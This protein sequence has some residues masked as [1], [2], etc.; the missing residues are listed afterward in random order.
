MFIALVSKTFRAI[1][2]LTYYL[3]TYTITLA[4]GSMLLLFLFNPGGVGGGGP[5]GGLIF[6]IYITAI[7]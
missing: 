3:I 4:R 6:R 1:R 2:I 7:F 5:K